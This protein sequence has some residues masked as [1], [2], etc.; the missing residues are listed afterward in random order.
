MCGHI[1]QQILYRNSIEIECTYFGTIKSLDIDFHNIEFDMKVNNF[2]MKH[3]IE[4]NINRFVIF[5]PKVAT[6][7]YTITEDMSLYYIIDS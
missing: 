1:Q 5:L 3:W 4:A 2:S 6:S 7:G